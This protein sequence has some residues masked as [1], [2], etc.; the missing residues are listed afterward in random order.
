[1]KTLKFLSC[2]LIPLF[3][4]ACSGLDDGQDPEEQ[5]PAVLT[6]SVSPSV[7]KADGKDTARIQ[8]LLDGEAVDISEVTFF[9]SGSD[10]DLGWTSFDYTTTTPGS[11]TFY[12]CC[13]D[14]DTRDKPLTITAEEV[15]SDPQP[16][17]DPDPDPDPDPE[18]EGRAFVHRSLLVDFTSVKCGY[19][20]YMAATMNMFEQSA[21]YADRVVLSALHCSGMGTDPFV[22]ADASLFERSVGVG[23]YPFMLVD[24][25]YKLEGTYQPAQNVQVIGTQIKNFQKEPARAG[26]AATVSR[27]GEQVVVSAEVKAAETA[28][29]RIGAFLMEDGLYAKQTNYGGASLQGDFNTHHHV[30]RKIDSKASALDFTGHSLGEI[31]AGEK[32]DYTF[33]WTLDSTWVPENCSVALFVTV[34]DENKAWYVTN[35]VHL[36]SLSGAYP[37]EYEE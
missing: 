34:Q 27:D 33:S 31:A 19:C 5:T 9:E 28:S 12:V 17:P 25:R 4:T 2:V 18:P 30:I 37:F 1:M 7:I 26:I 36:A 13:G 3:A 20:P 11:V 16:E 10:K 22:P 8:V 23:G 24:Y 32:A 6:A 14:S 15:G 29:F 35:A 21:E